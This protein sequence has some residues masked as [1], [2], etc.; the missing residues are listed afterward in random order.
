M[1]RLIEGG[2]FSDRR[3]IIKDEILKRC[4]EGKKTFLIVPE[5]QTVATEREFANFLPPTSPLCFEATNFTR[6]ANTVL[7]QV[8]GIAGKPLDSAG[9]MLLTWRTLTELAPFLDM[10]GNSEIN[11]G[12]VSS[13]LKAMKEASSLGLSPEMLERT[14]ERLK[15]EDSG[16]DE[17]L[18]SKLSDLS[19]IS[20]LYKKILTENYSDSDDQL[21]LLVRKIKARGEELFSDTKI[22]IDGFTSF[23]EPQYSL[24][25]ILI[26][27]TDTTVSLC[28]PKQDK[29]RYEYR[30]VR[31]AHNR[32]IDAAATAGAE[33]SLK[34]VEGQPKTPM[35][36][37]EICNNLWR[38]NGVIDN[39]CLQNPE[40]FRIFEAETPYDEC[41][42]V[43]ADIKRRVI[44]GAAYSDFAVIARGIDGYGGILSTAFEK[45]EIP[46]FLSKRQDIATYEVIK[47]I[48]SAFMAVTGG[49]S[50][51]DIITYSKCSLC[52][53][54]RELA[55]EFELYSEKWQINGSRFT[56]GEMW[57]MNPDG[58]AEHRRR[59][60]E[61]KLLRID[62]AR[63]ALITPLTN[64]EAALTG[65][66]A[67]SHAKAL[68]AFMTELKL[69]QKLKARAEKLHRSGNSE[70]ARDTER[71]YPA[72]CD[73]LDTVCDILGEC[74]VSP[75]VFLN[76]LK[77]AFAEAN[78]GKIPCYL[79]RVTAGSADTLRLFGKKHIY[80]LGV[81]FGVFPRSVSD[82]AYFTDKDRKRLDGAGLSLPQENESR[83]ARE[84]YYFI[85]ALSWGE[86]SVTLIYPERDAGFKPMLPSDAIY[87]ISEL[88]NGKISPR[89]ISSLSAMERTYCKEYAIEH[90]RSAGDSEA[91]IEA[92]LR[93]TGMGDKV[94]LTKRPMKNSSLSL[95]KEL[96]S[97]Y[98]GSS[99]PLSQS[100]IDKFVGCPMSYFCSYNLKLSPEKRAEFD[101]SNIGTF[102][103]SVL[104]NFF[105]KLTEEDRA[106][107]TLSDK[108][109]NE[110]I[111]SVAKRYIEASFEGITKRSAR[112]EAQIERL[113]RSARPVVDSLCKEFS[114][115]GYKP[116]FFELKIEKGKDGSPSP[117]VFKTS[118]GREIYINGIVDRVDAFRQGEDVYVRVV[119]YKT[120]NKIFSP[121]DIAEGKN[122]Q[123]FLYLKSIVETDSPA[124]KEKLGIGEGG[125]MIPAGV[126]YV[127]ADIGDAKIK[128]SSEEDAR[129]EVERMQQRIGMVLSDGENLSAMNPDYLP[130]KIDEKTGEPTKS[131][132]KNLYTADGW[133]S[134]CETI[135]SVMKDIGDRITSG[136][137][138]AAPLE[139]G[140]ASSA[141]R[142]CDYKAVCRNAKVGGSKW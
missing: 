27:L 24:I 64:L 92:A 41:D 21:S 38:T 141:C 133:D 118:D 20:A 7:R 84:L 34:R 52:G 85:R 59:G 39:S 1:L 19:K 108:E 110:I 14:A 104:E 138:C 17:R 26:K 28:L 53:V 131:T 99:M 96:A 49:Y 44:G 10:T 126:I 95:S 15:E 56:D 120:G 136:E 128:R 32:L 98:Y 125:K 90:L 11:A 48:Y 73:S 40:E 119:D 60:T 2:F 87:K 115:S 33:V 69:E 37:T 66:N 139:A 6:F 132:A 94:E 4:E 31:G 76:I 124:F 70:A 68:F 79:D 80:I 46:L 45:A 16:A 127:K 42:F 51:K 105:R 86:E 107:G 137:I 5:Q 61:E 43:A 13:A 121:S 55:D 134:I 130:F 102:I 112:T 109:K 62:G 72:I 12:L 75:S 36:I 22:Y 8:G 58:Y 3:D 111:R 101:A 97:D 78:I 91:S 116:L 113:I 88:T 142:Y 81:N 67:L 77:V 89:K 74:K 140:K 9:R 65:E 122:L 123:M 50:R 82:E 100:R 18:I 25:S 103:H 30:E 135:S 117:A 29:D 129:A 35:I 93:R 106:A 47:L 54:E 23:T 71:L 57:N 63:R 83:S 114:G